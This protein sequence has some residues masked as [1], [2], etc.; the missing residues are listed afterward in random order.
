VPPCV[1]RRTLISRCRGLTALD[2]RPVFPQVSNTG[3]IT[4]QFPPH[5]HVS[6]RC[7]RPM[8]SQL[9]DYITCWCSSTF[10]LVCC[11][12]PLQERKY[13][14]A[15]W[16]EMKTNSAGSPAGVEEQQQQQLPTASCHQRSAAQQPLPSNTSTQQAGNPECC[17]PPA[18]PTPVHPQASR[19]T[20]QAAHSTA[21]SEPQSDSPHHGLH[22]TSEGQ[23]LGRDVLHP[24]MTQLDAR[25][26]VMCALTCRW[27]ADNAAF[28]LHTKRLEKARVR[29]KEQELAKYREQG[30][31]SGLMSLAWTSVLLSSRW[32][33]AFFIRAYNL[34]GL[35]AP[36]L[37]SCM[38]VGRPGCQCTG[39]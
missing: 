4:T 36:P 21:G 15:W 9:L 11:L 24:V 5:Q 38:F 2:H 30:M 8:A 22:H 26:L 27:W 13:A 12:Q 35:H 25:S 14:E 16:A 23:Q 1:C 32:Q 17:V 33:P 31:F 18:L 34:K 29:Q 10:V 39:V 6:F 20:Q 28:V 3:G 7:V 19:T 37:P